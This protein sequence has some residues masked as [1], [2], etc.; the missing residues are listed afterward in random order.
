MLLDLQNRVNALE[1]KQDYVKTMILYN[2]SE[3]MNNETDWKD[4]LVFVWIPRNDTN[5]AI[6]SGFFYFRQSSPLVVLQREF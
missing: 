3:T 5:N 1:E 6:L 2:S 4:A